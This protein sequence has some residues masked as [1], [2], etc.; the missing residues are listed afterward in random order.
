MIAP[1]EILI[2]DDS[3]MVR[4]ALSDIFSREPDLQVIGMASDPFEAAMIMRT[5]V[6]DVITL[7]IEMP[8]MNGLTFL[9]KLM[10]QHPLPVVV[11]STLTEKGTETAIRALEFGA[12]DILA[13]PKLGAREDIEKNAQSLC[14][15]IRAAA[16]ANLSNLKKRPAR[17]FEVQHGVLRNR[18]NELN[19]LQS[20]RYLIA[21]GASTGGTEVLKN[22]LMGLPDNTSGI[23]IVQHMPQGFTAQFANRLNQLCKLEVKEAENGDWVGPGRAIIARGDAHLRVTRGPKGW[24][25]IIDG[26]TPQVNRH[27]PSVDVL[28]ESVAQHGGKNSIGCLLTGMGKDG[29]AGLLAMR[30]AGA[31]TVAQDE[32]TSVVFGMPRQ[33]IEIGAVE[34]IEPADKIGQT[35]LDLL[36]SMAA[37]KPK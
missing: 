20:S 16:K 21:I 32:A 36:K 19:Q 25:V 14:Q 4:H 22:V 7:D 23:V 37:N 17:A 18:S 2:V 6:P 30:K 9:Q 5:Q 13:K 15:T 28:F 12:A 27:R 31:R 35:L 1:I 33:A 26:E 29:A 3:A 8:R 10:K 11:I 34:L 24:E